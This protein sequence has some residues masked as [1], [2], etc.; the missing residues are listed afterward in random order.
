MNNTLKVSIKQQ[1]GKEVCYPVCDAAKTLARIAGTS[2]LTKETLKDIAALGYRVEIVQI[3][4]F[5]LTEEPASRTLA[6]V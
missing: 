2:T 4:S 6:R 1:Y 5:R 3:G